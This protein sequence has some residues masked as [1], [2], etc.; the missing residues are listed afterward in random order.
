MNA[1]TQPAALV[2][3]LRLFPATTPVVVGGPDGYREELALAAGRP[4]AAAIDGL[5]DWIQLFARDRAAL[6]AALP[7]V[8]AALDDPGILW[9]AYPKRSSKIQTDLTR[10]AGWDAVAGADLMWLSLVSLDETWSAF[11]LR[12]Y[13][14]GEPRQTF[15]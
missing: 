4:I 13:R 15:R 3:K 14:P 8:G 9:I 10:D 2:R 5:H 6:E 12:R 1:S 7:A 11:S